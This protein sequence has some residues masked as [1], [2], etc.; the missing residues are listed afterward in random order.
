MTNKMQAFITNG[1]PTFHKNTSHL[2]ALLEI[3]APKLGNDESAIPKKY[4]YVFNIDRSSSM[5]RTT[6]SDRTS[7][8]EQT[9][10]TLINIINWM[11]KDTNNEHYMT[12]IL[13]DH[14]TET[15]ATDILINKENATMLNDQINQIQPRGY[16]NIELALKVANTIIDTLLANTP[17]GDAHTEIIHIF[18][19]DG[20]P[21]IG[22][23]TSSTLASLSAA[24]K[25]KSK[26]YYIGF[27]LDHNSTLLQTLAATHDN[28][29][30]FADSL[31]TCGMVYSD[32]LHEIIYNYQPSI[33]LSTEGFD[34]YNYK[35]NV[36]TNTYKVPN[37]AYN[38]S[39]LYHI[40]QPVKHHERAQLSYTLSEQEE[41]K[42]LDIVF[43]PD[44]NVKIENHIWRQKTLEILYNIQNAEYSETRANKFLKQIK[45]Y[46]AKSNQT[47]NTF[48]QTLV[49]DIFVAITVKDTEYQDMYTHTRQ[50]SQ[51]GQRGYTVKNVQHIFNVEKHEFSQS[52]ATNYGSL[53]LVKLTRSISQLNPVPSS[54]SLPIGTSPIK[55]SRTFQSK[56]PLLS[57]PNHRP[58]MPLFNFSSNKTP[59]TTNVV[60]PPTTIQDLMPPTMR[61]SV[62]KPTPSQPTPIPSR[63]TLTI[64]SFTPYRQR[65]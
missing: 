57:K 33:I 50:T 2:F 42:P 34:I 51:G 64:P 29:Y 58:L 25:T 53:D 27:G 54:Q 12:I 15:I 6:P 44:D 40:R 10:H 46:M 49:D 65:Y 32:I 35:T 56:D 3:E 26:D 52:S 59:S 8:M 11:L 48:L 21:T 19:T 7:K 22:D 47:T 41:F 14:E 38:S 62:D 61:R 43:K 1:T 63:P 30:H 20:N 60:Y 28:N 55:R 37:L 4:H 31:E 39:K 45:A 5:S 16:T 13:F 18:M 36:W 9:I 24:T 23:E 17:P